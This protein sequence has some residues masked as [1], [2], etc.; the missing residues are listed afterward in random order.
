MN[1]SKAPMIRR[2]GSSPLAGLVSRPKSVRSKMP[3]ND[4]KGGARIPQRKLGLKTQS[5]TDQ[6]YIDKFWSCEENWYES[7]YGD[8]LVGA[9]F[10]R[11]FLKD[12]RSY[13]SLLE[14]AH[15]YNI[16]IPM[17][18]KY[19]TNSG[20]PT[21][22]TMEEIARAKGVN[23][24][25]F[26]GF[27]PTEIKR[28]FARNGLDYEAE[29]ARADRINNHPEHIAFKKDG[30]RAKLYKARRPE[31]ADALKDIEDVPRDPAEVIAIQRTREELAY[32]VR[33]ARK[34]LREEA[35]MQPEAEGDAPEGSPNPVDAETGSEAPE[36][37]SEPG[38]A[39]RAGAPHQPRRRRPSASR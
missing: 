15:R 3:T 24:L 27:T 14:F 38:R 16:G 11:A 18:H 12:K 22:N 8:S 10:S 9:A 4:K 31:L 5:P 20:N 6:P 2:L 28:A 7:P 36:A 13:E 33:Q 30:R 29:Q 32:R 39:R 37:A 1:L 19:G 23:L 26:L 21:L 35:E 25:E 34:R 17:A